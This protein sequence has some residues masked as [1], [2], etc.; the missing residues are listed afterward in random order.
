[1]KKIILPLVILSMS[2][3]ACTMPW[4]HKNEGEAI[5]NNTHTSESK[6]KD[7]VVHTINYTL[8]DGEKI[9]D[10]KQNYSF[11]IGKRMPFIASGM[12]EIVGSMKVGEKKSV[13]LP[14]EKLYGPS[15]L[16]NT[17]NL[18]QFVDTF[19]TTGSIDAYADRITVS[20]PKAQVLMDD[21]SEYKVGDEVK[22]VM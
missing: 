2:L 6:I 18:E 7:Q 12:D 10:S 8:K 3:S 14:A 20:L 19:T 9:I 11:V 1:M 15:M 21:K 4:S 16:T 22:V 17:G 5:K 13:Q